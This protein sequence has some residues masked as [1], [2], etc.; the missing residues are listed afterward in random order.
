MSV[1]VRP[2]VGRVTNVFGARNPPSAALPFHRG[3]DFG[4]GGGSAAELVVRAPMSGYLSQRIASGAG[5]YGKHFYLSSGPYV[6]ILAHL[7]DFVVGSGQ[8]TVGQH[9]GTMG[10]T[11]TVAVHLHEELL[12]N[13]VRVDPML[14]TDQSSTA[15]EGTPV[16]IR[17]EDDMKLIQQTSRG[18]AAVGAGYWKQL[19]GEEVPYAIQLWGAPTIFADGDVG[20]RQFDLARSVSINGVGSG[21]TGVQ[22]DLSAAEIAAAV[23]A[24]LEVKFTE[25]NAN[26]N[27]Q[28]THFE[29]TP[30]G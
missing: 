29:I 17:I 13:G 22:S 23:K 12:I 26:V 1:L 5:T 7:A 14:Y 16:P 15:G 3:T 28:P 24:A 19:T 20:A 6:V 27:D 9:I 30:K 10:S 18:I 21:P 2:S 8:V 11:G 4:H 25:V